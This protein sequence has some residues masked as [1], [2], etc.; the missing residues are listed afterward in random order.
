MK[1]N[2]ILGIIGSSLLGL[3]LGA[4]VGSCGKN[5]NNSVEN[6]IK[7]P[8]RVEKVEKLADLVLDK[9]LEGRVYSSSQVPANMCSRYVRLVAKDLFGIAYPGVDAWEL[10]NSP[11]IDEIPVKS[12]KDLEKLAEFEFLLPGMVL[13]LY[14]PQSKYNSRAEESGAGYTHVALYLGRDKNGKLYFSDKFGKN[15]RTRVSLDEMLEMGNLEP[16]EL[17]Y[18]NKR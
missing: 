3:A 5:Y 8:A 9:I 10:R 14:N 7:E 2:D 17:L 1:R 15:T 12:N 16:R 11:G 6:A 4:G 18:F 13:G